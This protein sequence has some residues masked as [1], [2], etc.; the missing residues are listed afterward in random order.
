[1]NE[2]KKDVVNPVKPK[3]YERFVDDTYRRRKRNEPDN[4]FDKMNSY[5]FNIKLTIEITSQK[6][7]DNKILRTSNK[8]L[9]F[10]CQKENKTTDS[11]EFGS[12]K[13]L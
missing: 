4:L 13:K 6:F 3:F 2:M 10:M 8:I 9:C 1:M 12:T 5:H 7:L 11:L